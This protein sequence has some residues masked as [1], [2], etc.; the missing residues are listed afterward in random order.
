MIGK[1]TLLFSRQVKTKPNSSCNYN[2][3]YY[4]QNDFSRIVIHETSD[5]LSDT[6]TVHL[7]DGT[8]VLKE[9]NALVVFC[10]TN[11]RSEH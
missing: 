9:H 2:S 5:I 6:K 4:I 7:I 8:K 11:N 3:G 1:S 10:I